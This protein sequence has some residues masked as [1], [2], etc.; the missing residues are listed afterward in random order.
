MMG[1]A[2]GL[3]AGQATRQSFEELEYF[4]ATELLANRDLASR[5]DTVNLENVLG[6]IKSDCHS[7]HRGWLPLSESDNDSLWH[8]R[9]R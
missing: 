2:T 6:E 7:G 1:G 9:C 5:V 8:I 3:D 4:R